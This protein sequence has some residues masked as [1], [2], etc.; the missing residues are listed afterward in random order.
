M[1]YKIYLI[2][3]LK[4]KYTVILQIAFITNAQDKGVL[5]IAIKAINLKK[6]KQKEKL[7]LI[8]FVSY[9]DKKQKQKQNIKEK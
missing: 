5:Y 8:L 9:E 7:V 2:I 1:I 3:D 6:K 4:E